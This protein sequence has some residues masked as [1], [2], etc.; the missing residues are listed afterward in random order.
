MTDSYP[1]TSTM[2]TFLLQQ[3]NPINGAKNK[4][5]TNRPAKKEVNPT[6][7]VFLRKT[8]ELVNS[9]D[10][11]VASWYVHCIVFCSDHAIRMEVPFMAVAS[12]LGLKVIKF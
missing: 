2:E 1:K 12:C 4:K 5:R 8:F 9:C 7:P 10:P 6:A 11:S 3:P